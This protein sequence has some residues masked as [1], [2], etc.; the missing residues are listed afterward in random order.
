MKKVRL[1]RYL[2]VHQEIILNMPE[3]MDD[4]SDEFWDWAD[5]QTENNSLEWITEESRVD[6]WDSD[7]FE[8]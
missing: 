6:G 3:G 5:A 2:F 8:D 1:A 7:V 4:N